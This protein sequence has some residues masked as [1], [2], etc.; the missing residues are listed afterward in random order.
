MLRAFSSRIYVE[1][2][3][4][5]WGQGLCLRLTSRLVSSGTAE[6]AGEATAPEES[7]PTEARVVI[8]GGGIIGC[9]VAYHLAK[10]GWKDVLL[11][12]QGR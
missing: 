7:F 6:S 5:R 2:V 3:R 12:E 1:V 9:S 10:A 4:K 11:L 8:G